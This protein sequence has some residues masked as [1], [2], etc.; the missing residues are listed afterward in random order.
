MTDEVELTNCSSV[1]HWFDVG[2]SGTDGNGV[3]VLYCK[4]CGDVRPL[5]VP[6]IEAPEMEKVNARQEAP[7]K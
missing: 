7:D 2:W 1:R 3:G 4:A 5:E 6:I